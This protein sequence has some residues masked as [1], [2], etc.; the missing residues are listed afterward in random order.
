MEAEAVGV[1]GA[2]VDFVQTNPGEAN[3]AYVLLQYHGHPV[4]QADYPVDLTQ[5][6]VYGVDWSSSQLNFTLDGQVVETFTGDI[7]TGPLYLKMHVGPNKPGAKCGGKAALVVS[8]V[9]VTG[10]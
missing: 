4:A 6:H 9:Q 1:N 7:P 10:S 2:E 8:E 5:Q 3:T